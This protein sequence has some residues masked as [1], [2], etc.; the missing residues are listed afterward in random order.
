MKKTIFTMALICG[1]TAFA[2]SQ[3][4][5]AFKINAGMT[6][7]SV[8]SDIDGEKDNTDDVVGFTAGVAANMALGKHF[9]F[10]PG[11][12]FVQKGGKETQDQTSASVI[13]D[14]VEMPLNLLYNTAGKSGQFFIGA[15][16][17]FSYG[18]G[19]KIKA[20]DN[21]VSGSVKVKFGNGEGDLLKP[22]EMGANFLTGYQ[23]KSGLALSVNYNIGLSDVLPDSESGS[24]KN[25]YVGLKVG[26]RF[27]SKK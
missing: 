25:E 12:N 3:S 5:V 27:H 16:P 1:L 22:F 26:Y 19:G 10:E 11:L 13:L 9:S 4:K 20:E 7:G 15:G 23:F 2:V 21:G 24:W 8:K 17:S 18:V 6:S 14:Y